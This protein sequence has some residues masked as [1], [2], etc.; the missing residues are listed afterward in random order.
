M[1]PCL[2]LP[3]CAQSRGCQLKSLSW[4]ST[5]EKKAELLTWEKVLE[6]CAERGRIRG[7]RLEGREGR[8][9]S[10]LATGNA[11]GGTERLS[12]GSG[13]CPSQVASCHLASANQLSLPY[14]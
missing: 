6:L 10:F 3:L 8:A 9:D 14:Y 7:V 1:R 5:E 2:S 13:Q 11:W 4:L 12:S